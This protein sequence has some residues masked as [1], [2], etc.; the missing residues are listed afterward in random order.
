MLDRGS[1]LEEPARAHRT[2]LKQTSAPNTRFGRNETKAGGSRNNICLCG[3]GKGKVR[4]DVKERGLQ[5]QFPA[6]A[7]SC[8]PEQPQR[9]RVSYAAKP[10]I[11]S[12]A[13]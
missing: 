3:G 1:P 5:D 13:K 12:R 7:S 8:F 9:P 2:R 11:K 10:P 6:L 4:G